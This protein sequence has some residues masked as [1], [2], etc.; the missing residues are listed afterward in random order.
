MQSWCRTWPPNRSRHPCKTKTSQETQRSLQKF[1]EQVLPAV[2][3]L[4][5]LNE[6]WWAGSM[7]CYTYLRKVTDLLFDGQTSIWKTFW[8]TIERFDYSIWFIVWVWPHLVEGSVK[9]L[10]IWKGNLLWI[11][12][13]TR[14]VRG[15]NLEGWRTGSKLWGV[16]DNGRIGNLLKKT[17][18]ERGD[19]SQS[20]KIC[21]TSRR[22]RRIKLFGGDQELRTYILIWHRPIQSH[23][24]YLGE[25]G[26]RRSDKWLLIHTRKI[27]FPPSRW[28]QS[29]T[30]FVER[31]IFPHSNQIHWR[32]QNYV[33][34]F[35]CQAK[36]M[37]RWF[38]EYRWISKFVWFLDRFHT[39]TLFKEKPPD[40]FM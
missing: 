10:S 20:R 22:R 17:Q 12:P 23:L 34:E 30:L 19:I 6:N 4:S 9:N 33:F 36:E 5:G 25:S 27:H 26:C 21:F 7:E 2:L 32:I 13:R 18:C 15:G 8:V 37:H 38:S 14:S 31:R 40:G 35:G 29:Q 24:D 16:G 11:V 1:L 28:T 39:I 3:L